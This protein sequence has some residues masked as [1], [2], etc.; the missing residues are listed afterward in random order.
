MIEKIRNRILLMSITEILWPGC[1]FIL[2]FRLHL[3]M[4]QWFHPSIIRIT[5]KQYND[6]YQFQS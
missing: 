5:I 6:L 4:H 2:V 1:F 3:A